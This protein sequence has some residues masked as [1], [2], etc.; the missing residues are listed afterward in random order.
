MPCIAP[1][2]SEGVGRALLRIRAGKLLVETVEPRGRGQP[3]GIP[4]E[5]EVGPGGYE[6]V[7]LRGL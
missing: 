3:V 5:G 4:C 1:D 6:G 7:D 2:E